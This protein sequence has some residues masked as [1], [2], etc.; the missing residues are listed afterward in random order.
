MLE[1]AGGGFWNAR[2]VVLPVAGGEERHAARFA[3]A[4]VRLVLAV[5]A[6]ERASRDGR[7]RKFRRNSRRA[8]GN[9]AHEA[10]RVHEVR[11]A[12][13]RPDRGFADRRGLAQ[14]TIDEGDPLAPRTDGFLARHQARKVERFVRALIG[15]V[16]A[17]DVA[18]L[19][20]PAVVAHAANGSGADSLRAVRAPRFD[21]LVDRVEEQRERPAVPHAHAAVLADRERAL[22]L[23]LE[24]AR[25]EIARIARRSRGGLA[26]RAR[27][28]STAQPSSF[29][30]FS[31]RPACDFS[32]FAS[33]SNH[34]AISA[35]PSS[36]AVFAKPGYIV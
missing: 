14:N 28:G 13:L 30:A 32:A 34:S 33:V 12:R 10:V 9:F 23:L 35:K 1:H 26:G 2:E 5:P 7:Q 11:D 29:D 21:L 15:R 17:L 3:R 24:I 4:L 19:A 16:R 25:V 31:K 36:R 20:L 6:R 27:W 8:L 18:E 22:E